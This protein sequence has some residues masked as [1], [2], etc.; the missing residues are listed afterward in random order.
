[1]NI[2]AHSTILPDNVTVQFYPRNVNSLIDQ[3]D[4]KPSVA[5]FI[6]KSTLL[7]KFWE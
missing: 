4:H 1:M 3:Y 5:E 7:Y 6:E 2:L